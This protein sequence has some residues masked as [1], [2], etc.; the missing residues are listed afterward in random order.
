MSERERDARLDAMVSREERAS[1]PCLDCEAGEPHVCPKLGPD[2]GP[3][4]GAVPGLAAL[5]NVS[6]SV[7]S[8]A[9][10]A[11]C[12]EE[13][14]VHEEAC[15]LAAG[16]HHTLAAPRWLDAQLT[17]HAPRARTF[18]FGGVRIHCE[19]DWEDDGSQSYTEHLSEALTQTTAPEST[20]RF[21]P[22]GEGIP[23]DPRP[24][25]RWSCTA[26]WYGQPPRL[27]VETWP[28]GAAVTDAFHETHVKAEEAR[29]V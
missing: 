20:A 3:V 10:N 6:L 28:C 7:W 12:N 17:E 23:A 2:V 8:N 13:D 14:A 25:D 11:H 18:G 26:G 24:E 21:E 19:C 1:E 15:R 4:T 16:L 29:G 9:C 5:V 22:I 27:G